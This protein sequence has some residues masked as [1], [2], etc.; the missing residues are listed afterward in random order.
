MSKLRTVLYHPTTNLVVALILVGTSL[1]EI[2]ESAT[3]DALRMA[4]GGMEMTVAAYDGVLVYGLVH[5]M[6]AIAELVEDVERGVRV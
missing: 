4:V 3:G 6:R 5:L 2:W 1:A